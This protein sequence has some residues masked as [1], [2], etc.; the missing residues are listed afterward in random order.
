M[1]ELLKLYFDI[2]LFRKGPQ[3]VPF[4]GSIFRL[5]I[6]VYASV[7]F[8]I[9][10]LSNNSLNALLQVLVEVMLILGLSWVILF[11][12]KRPARYHQTAS[13]LLGTDALISLFSIPAMATLVGQ[14]TLL[15]FIVIV[16]L[17][18]WHW[19]VSGHIFC[20]A[21]EQSFTFGLGIA[22]L[23]ILTSYIVMDFL[24]FVPD[25]KT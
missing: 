18:I 2:C 25:L 1:Y 21:L 22:F 5:L 6:L 11:F 13:A 15:A 14:G 3:D 12:A 10:I 7:S 4:S 9:M 24:F 16:L 20:N 23:Y 17:M 8:L 19:V